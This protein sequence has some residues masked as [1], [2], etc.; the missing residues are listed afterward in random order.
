MPRLVFDP[1]LV[2]PVGIPPDDPARW[3]AFVERLAEWATDVRAGVGPAVFA[4]ACEYY[5]EFGYPD[6]PLSLD[7]PPY[8]R[9]DYGRALN[10]VLGR[11]IACGPGLSEHETVPAHA[12]PREL[13]RL[14]VSDIVGSVDCDVA[15]IATD[16]MHWTPPGPKV[17]L[18]PGPP[19]SLALCDAPFSPLLVEKDLRVHAYFAEKRIHVV[20]GRPSDQVPAV[21]ALLLGMEVDSIIWRPGEK[22]KPPRDI[23]KRWSKLDPLRDVTACLTGCIGHSASETARRAAD[24][25]G[26]VHLRAETVDELGRALVLEAE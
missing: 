11:L 1:L 9:R 4:H 5:A 16:R 26:L 20:G 15:G 12:G 7:V 19:K 14:L 3:E 10:R 13:T 21:L 8:L 2:M 22:G 17:C 23:K 18:E 6:S 25:R 24:S